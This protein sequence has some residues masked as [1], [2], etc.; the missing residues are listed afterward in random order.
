ARGEVPAAVTGHGE[1]DE[2]EHDDDQ[3]PA[4]QPAAKERVAAPEVP[5]RVVTAHDQRVVAVVAVVAAAGRRVIRVIRVLVGTELLAPS[6]RGHPGRVPPAGPRQS[7]WLSLASARPG[8]GV[9]VEPGGFGQTL[10][11][12]AE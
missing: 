9:E 1:Q 3:A 6:V 7:G 4:E 8:W 5:V 12:D 11:T 10:D 2:R